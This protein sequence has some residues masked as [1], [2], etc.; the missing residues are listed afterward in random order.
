MTPLAGIR[1]KLAG[2]QANDRTGGRA[3]GAPRPTE[4]IYAQGSDWAP[5]AP[6]LRVVPPSALVPDPA[7]SGAG[8]SGAHGLTGA[9][10]ATHDF[11]GAPAATRVDP[12]LDFTWWE[13]PPLRGL[14]ADSF[15]VRWTGTLVAPVTGRYALGLRGL[16]GAKLV[17][18]DSTVVQW[19]D[20]HVV[21]TESQAVDL[22]AGQPR[23]IRVEYFDRRALRGHPAGVGAAASRTSW[24]RRSRRRGAPTRWCWCWASRRGSRARSCRCRCPASTG[25]DR[26]DLELPAEQDALLA[27]G[28]GD[29]EAGGARAPQR[30]RARR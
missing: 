4:V 21:L 10:F 16:G 2:G 29:R 13:E 28:R 20:R 7:V 27:R 18:D 14:P 15:S 17:L 9:Y 5:A 12:A 3:A 8:H 30:Q 26:T 1:R 24:R 25:G 11:S 19:S 22:V 6:V 23:R